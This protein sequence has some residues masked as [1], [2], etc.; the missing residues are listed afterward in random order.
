M[1]E[2][3]VRL[4]MNL[5]HY[6]YLNNLIIIISYCKLIFDAKKDQ[7][8]Q[9]RLQVRINNVFNYFDSFI[10]NHD[11]SLII[12]SDVSHWVSEIMFSF[13]SIL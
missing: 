11:F 8:K 13:G 9:W 10:N 12:E 1:S 3:W 6:L 4:Q 2:L 5:L 7:I